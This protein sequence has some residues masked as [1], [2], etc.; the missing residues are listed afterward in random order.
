MN[1]NMVPPTNAGSSFSAAGTTSCASSSTDDTPTSHLIDTN[2][3]SSRHESSKAFQRPEFGEQETILIHNHMKSTVL[4][5]NNHGIKLMDVLP[6]EVGPYDVLFVGRGGIARLFKRKEYSG[7]LW[8]RCLIDLVQPG[9]LMCH[10]K[11]EKMKLS[12]WIVDKVRSCGG[13]LMEKDKKSGLYHDV[14]DRIAQMRTSM[15]LRDRRR[16]KT[17]AQAYANDFHH[18]KEFVSL[19]SVTLADVFR[20]CE[21][22]FPKFQPSCQSLSASENVHSTPAGS[23]IP[24]IIP[25]VSAGSVV[26]TVPP[27]FGSLTA[28]LPV[29]PI[30][31]VSSTFVPTFA[32]STPMGVGAGAANPPTGWTSST[33]GASLLVHPSHRLMLEKQI[34]QQEIIRDH[35]TIVKIQERLSQLDSEQEEEL[36]R[37]MIERQMIRQKVRE[38]MRVQEEMDGQMLR[39]EMENR[40]KLQRKMQ[41][42][43]LAPVYRQWCVRQNPMVPVVSPQNKI[44][45]NQSCG[46]ISRQDVVQ[47]EVARNDDEADLSRRHNILDRRG[48]KDYVSSDCDDKTDDETD[49]D[50]III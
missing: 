31:L 8:Y 30:S 22:Y 36:Q 39:R 3:E 41:G 20:E 12:R 1:L 37:C 16:W 14:G 47:E 43:Q 11:T 28:Q 26:V 7:Y 33:L 35:Q 42:R 44:P 17:C 25:S 50:D 45:E 4:S 5:N 15:F 29:I 10:G 38:E 48:I 9:F 18:C 46:R 24:S 13:R 27:Y 32:S 40:A 19:K 21:I 34:L 49:E 6:N 23:M 2:G